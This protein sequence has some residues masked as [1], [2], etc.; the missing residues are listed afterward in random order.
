VIGVVKLYRL[1]LLGPKGIRISLTASD[2][3]TAHEEGFHVVNVA[4]HVWENM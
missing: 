4:S 1:T 2:I 3:S